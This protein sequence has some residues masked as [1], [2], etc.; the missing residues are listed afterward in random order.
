MNRLSTAGLF[1]N[2]LSKSRDSIAESQ[3]ALKTNR[4]R[5]QRGDCD[6]YAGLSALLHTNWAQNQRPSSKPNS[7]ANLVN[8]AQERPGVAIN[9]KNAKDPIK[10]QDSKR[11]RQC[12][13]VFLTQKWAFVCCCYIL[14][15]ADGCLCHM[16]PK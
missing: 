11:P 9:A 12:D 15:L 10:I 13:K 4:P 5:E 1:W 3:T 8:Q 7:Y 2:Q 6:W 14:K 16:R